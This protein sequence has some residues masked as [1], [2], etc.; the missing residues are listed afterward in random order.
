[1]N[2]DDTILRPPATLPQ[3]KRGEDGGAQE[4]ELRR[5]PP[6][7]HGLSREFVTRNQRERLVAGTIA[8]VAEHGYRDTSVTRIAAAAQV[9]RRTFYTYFST[10]EKCFLASYDLFESHLLAALAEGPSGGAWAAEVRAR[11]AVLLEVLVANP[12]LIRF[13]LV[14]PP[15]AGGEILTRQRRFLGQLMEALVAGAPEAARAKATPVELEA[16][17]GALAAVLV[18]KVEAGEEDG[19][20]DL[21]AELVELVLVPFI[22]RRRA[23]AAA[24]KS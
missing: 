23:A 18:A 20:A 21:D 6:G 11:V 22:G 17:A 8:A 1:V 12:D 4:D 10:K 13:S 2:T 16:A 19:L 3:V 15:S 9:S 14:A 7:R 5:L 24:R